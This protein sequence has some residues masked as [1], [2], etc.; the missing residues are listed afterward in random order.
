MREESWQPLVIDALSRSLGLAPNGF[1]R[2][3][4]TRDGSR[5]DLLYVGGGRCV[6]FEMKQGEPGEAL[7]A[8]MGRDLRQLRHFG[9]SCHALYLVTLASPRRWGLSHDGRTITLDSL[10][11]QLL[12]PGVGWIVFD[13]LTHDAVILE[14]APDNDT[15]DED[16]RFLVDAVIS[17]LKR[18]TRD[19][20]RCR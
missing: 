19:A 1:H 11:R 7:R 3:V 10:E 8:L 18:Q 16:R 6:G 9:A 14:P 15:R 17:R 2:E 13:V 20:Q 5:L 12:P 4:P